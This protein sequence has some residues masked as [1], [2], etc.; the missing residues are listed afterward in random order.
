MYSQEADAV[1]N[2]IEGLLPRIVGLEAR[3]AAPP[4]DVAELRRRSDLIRYVV[5][6]TLDTML[7]PF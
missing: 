6:S 7:S 1:R 5:T 4:G 3:F 2:K